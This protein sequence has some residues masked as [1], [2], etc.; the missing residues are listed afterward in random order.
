MALT[1]WKEIVC[2]VW[3]FCYFIPFNFSLNSECLYI[4]WEIYVKLL[5]IHWL[6]ACMRM[7]I[8]VWFLVG[9]YFWNSDFLNS[10]PFSDRIFWP[11]LNVQYTSFR[12]AFS[13][14]CADLSGLGTHM[15]QLVDMHITVSV[16]WIPFVPFL[17]V[18]KGMV[19]SIEIKSIEVL[20]ISRRICT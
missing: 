3:Y 9:S 11:P 17:V 14:V 13:T 5:Y 4:F 18:S 1:I 20:G 2:S 12:Y 10:L 6:L 16:Y 7:K 15:A 8:N 19:R